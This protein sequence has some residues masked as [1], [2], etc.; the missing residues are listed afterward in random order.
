MPA[1]EQTMPNEVTGNVSMAEAMQ[2]IRELKATLAEAQRRMLEDEGQLGKDL[3]DEQRSELMRDMLRN[4]EHEL[5]PKIPDERTRVKTMVLML[6]LDIADRQLNRGE[7]SKQEWARL[8]EVLKHR[9]EAVKT[10]ENL[11]EAIGKWEGELKSKVNDA[12]ADEAQMRKAAYQVITA[13]LIAKL[14]AKEKEVD[15]AQDK[16]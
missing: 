10:V 1:L 7:D 9:P 11:E 12:E 13:A 15:A 2:R 6:V 16:P 14:R 5:L 4:F 8:K 3:S